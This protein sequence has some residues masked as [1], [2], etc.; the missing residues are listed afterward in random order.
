MSY[1]EG[2]I[3]RIKLDNV[4]TYDSVEFQCGPRLNVIIG[5]NGTGK[6]T[7]VCAICLGLAGKPSLLGRANHPTDF[8]KYGCKKACIELELYNQDGQNYIVKREISKEAPTNKWWVN[9]RSA[10]QK[11]IEELVARLN[12]QVGNL[13]QFLP[14]EKVADFAKMTEIDLLENTEKAVGSPDMFERHQQLKDSRSSARELETDHERL[15]ERLNVERQKNARV[16]QDVR[17]YEE[18]NKILQEI[19]TLKIKKVWV[20]YEEKRQLFYQHRT[21]RKTVEAELKTLRDAHA[22]LRRGIEECRAKK[23]DIASQVKAKSRELRIVA[24]QASAN[25]NALDGLTDKS[26]EIRSEM[27]FKQEQEDAR[28]RRLQDLRRQ[29]EALENDIQSL[30]DTVDVQPQIEQLNKSLREVT[31]NL[32]QVNH[33]GDSIRMERDKH[34]RDH[35]LI[36][37]DLKS[38]RNIENQRLELLRTRHKDTYSAVVWLRENKKM[39]KG[40]IHEP[41]MLCVNMRNPQQAKFLENHVS[42]NDLRAFVCETS[43]DLNLFMDLMRDE[44]KLRVNAVKAPADVNLEETRPSKP[45]QF[46]SKFGFQTYLRDMFTCPDAVMRFLCRQYRVHNIPVGTA[47]TKQQ[48]GNIIQ[49]H[50]ELT[51]FYTEDSQYQIKRSR[52][53]N[54]VS[55]RNIKLKQPS[56]LTTSMNYERERE[57]VKQQ[58]VESAAVSQKEQEYKELQDRSKQLDQQLN[59][60]REEKKQLMMRKDQ[61]KRLQSQIESKKKTILTVE[62]E[63]LNM[64]EEERKVRVKVAEVNESK[65]RLLTQ[66]VENT[67]R[68]LELCKDKVF[69]GVSHAEAVRACTSMEEENRGQTQALQQAESKFERLRERE[70]RC[71]REARQ[72]LADARKESNLG[73][74]DELPQALM[75]EMAHLPEN[76]DALNAL[77][78]EKQVRADLTIVADPRVIQEFQKRQVEIEKLERELAEK[79]RQL[80]TH[81][82]DIEEA[83]AHWIG[84]LQE[85]IE[86][87]NTKFSFFFQCLKCVG[88][89][90]LHVPDNP[91]EYSKYGVRIKVKFRDSEPLKELSPFHQS[92]GERSVTTVLYM[93]ALQEIARVPFRCVDEINQGM[94]PVNERKVFELVVTT[95]CTMSSSQ[96]FLLT[97]KLLPDLEYAEEMTVLCVYNGSN[98]LN[99]TEW[100]LNK[101]I[102]NGRPL[103]E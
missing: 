44:Q 49:Q 81:Q 65:L 34:Q 56:L 4:L 90:D 39:F 58:Q 9:G 8:I 29:L 101:F 1:C 74:N 48:V 95:V 55:S 13:T 76:V 40:T 84:P 52:Y 10:T 47:A 62:H 103:D 60:L 88:E 57:L 72:Q 6:S 87:I 15:I 35:A 51:C 77:I 70:E 54:S 38:L 94:D 41:I 98:M 7:I 11:N 68:C 20:E 96:Y 21:E 27:R 45:I 42:F 32:A 67:G 31:Q 5:P 82:A 26:V 91:E 78:D 19:K 100:D 46:Y 24:E 22:P 14:Q 50:P 18:R 16:E 33:Q 64:E 25:A 30:D 73:T 85:L 3:V 86:K 12:I 99:H 36:E 61:K 63:A 59:K 2:S 17:S 66:Y 83:K 93:M 71:K 92:G 80:A 43:E 89:V 28:K 53:D 23:D 97:P 37:K 102:K 75:Q 79:E 69:L